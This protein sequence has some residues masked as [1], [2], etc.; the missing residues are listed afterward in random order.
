MTEKKLTIV[1]K[2]EATIALLSGKTPA[3][4]FSIE[5]AM[6]FL[7]DRKAQT[8]KKNTPNG[9]RKMNAEQ[10]Q[11][12]ILKGD[13]LTAMA[14][15]GTATTT[16]D[17]AKATPQFADMSTQKLAG[18]FTRLVVDGL[19]VRETIKGKNYYSLPAPTED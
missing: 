16:K 17:F 1:E 2:Y 19:L 8:I 12:E 15:I 5:D 14:T 3:V 4:D 11:N 10:K 9:E 18:L 13:I 6:D 7:A